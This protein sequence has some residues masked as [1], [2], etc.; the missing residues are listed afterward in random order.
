MQKATIYL[1]E[2]LWRTFRKVCIDQGISASQQM[3]Q[4]IEQYLAQHSAS[5]D[6]IPRAQRDRAPQKGP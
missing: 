1:D 2:I 4:L 3:M 5:M 6:S